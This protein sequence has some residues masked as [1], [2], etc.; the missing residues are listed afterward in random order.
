MTHNKLLLVALILYLVTA[1]ASYAYFSKQVNATPAPVAV[2]VA[3]DQNGGLQIDPSAPK[4][5]TCPLNGEKYTAAEKAVWDQRRPLAIMVENSPDARPQSGL[6]RSD[7]IYETVAEGGVTRFMAVYLCDAARSDVTV[8]PVRSVRTYFLDW[9]SEYG[10]TPLFSHVLGANCSSE[11][12]GGPCKSDPRTQALEQLTKYGWR[13][14]KG[15]DLDQAAIGT[16]TY[17]RVENRLFNLLG[18]NVATEHSMVTKTNLLYKIGQ[19]RGWT[20]LDPE[21]EDWTKSFRAWKFKDDAPADK[22]GTVT[23][24]SHDFWSG[25]KQF[26]VKWDYD[27]A[28]NTYLRTMGGEPHKDLETGQQLSAKNVVIIFTKEQTSVDPLKH[29]LYT[30][31]GDGKALIFQDGQAI[32]GKWSKK[33][34]LGRTIFTNKKGEEIKFNP[35]RIWISTVGLNTPVTY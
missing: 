26:D 3:V 10:K 18:R 15:N 19:N 34:R 35:G 32:E 22:R 31:I 21:G 23:S 4:T 5:E 28:T 14:A 29:S 24:I 1:G 8:A 20:N 30:T 16:P 17:T 11:T 25:Y 7:V 13:Y 12:P 2:P 27:P 6:I 33:D 9:A